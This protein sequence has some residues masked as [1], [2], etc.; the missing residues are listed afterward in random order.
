M[1]RSMYADV[2]MNNCIKDDSTFNRWRGLTSHQNFR[3]IVSCR[4]FGSFSLTKHFDP[5]VY[6]LFLALLMGLCFGLAHTPSMAFAYVWGSLEHGI[7]HFS[8]PSDAAAPGSPNLKCRTIFRVQIFKYLICR[9][10]LF[11]FGAVVAAAGI[12]HS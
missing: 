10:W 2:H 5:I 8:M 11:T 12:F 4:I 1:Q 9:R 6:L 7:C 3:I